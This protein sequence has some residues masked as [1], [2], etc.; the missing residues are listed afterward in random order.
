MMTISTK[1]LGK[2]KKKKKKKKKNAHKIKDIMRN[3]ITR[4]V[5]LFDEKKNIRK[6]MTK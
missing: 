1:Y 3:Q 4:F 5:E 2:K 6:S